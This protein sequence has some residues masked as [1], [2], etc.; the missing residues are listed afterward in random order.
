MDAALATSN[1]PAP[2]NNNSNS[3]PVE[4]FIFNFSKFYWF[5]V[6]SVNR[7]VSKKEKINFSG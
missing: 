6:F 1:T 2:I 7:N 4:G 3:D 5:R